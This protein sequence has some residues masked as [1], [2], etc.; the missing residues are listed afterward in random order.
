MCTAM[1]QIIS[2]N[3]FLNRLCTSGGSLVAIVGAGVV[4][5]AGWGCL[6]RPHRGSVGAGVVVI[7]SNKIGKGVA[8]EAKKKDNPFTSL[9]KHPKGEPSDE[10]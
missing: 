5:D 10:R 7:D 4:V 1:E 9:L 3:N 2:I 6:H 8:K